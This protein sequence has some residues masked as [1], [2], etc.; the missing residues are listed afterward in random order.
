MD[1]RE[2]FIS[3]ICKHSFGGYAIEQIK[4]A[5]GLNKKIVNP[6]EKK[7]KS[8]LDF[9][10]VIDG[11]DTIPLME[12]LENKNLNHD[13]CGLVNLPHARDT[14]SL[15]HNLSI[16]YKG[17][18]NNEDTSNEVRL[19]SIP[20]GEVPIATMIYNKDGFTVYCKKY[21]DYWDWD[22]KKNPHRYAENV[23]NGKSFDGKNMMHCHRL[24]DM[25][26]EIGEGKGVIV[27]RPNREQLLSIRK[28]E[29]EYDELIM[30]AEKKIKLMDEVY[31]KS[32]LPMGVDRKFA[33]DILVKIRKTRYGL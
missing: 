11:Y 13:N 19:S 25:A 1:N 15:F 17:I 5:R 28:G 10:H 24:L 14:Y 27:R 6:M 21:K 31:D 16:P 33:D 26:I 4:K 7:R 12:F 8:I 30:D 18:T 32:S 2:K 29:C 23:K 22:K 3:K 20:K 9:C